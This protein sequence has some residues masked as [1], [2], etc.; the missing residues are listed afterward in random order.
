[1]IARSLLLATFVVV[2]PLIA[3]PA[4]ASEPPQAVVAPP[5]AVAAPPPAVA[6]FD[7]RQARAHQEAWSRHL[8]EPIVAQN[9]VGMSLVLIPP[10]EFLMGGSTE[11]LAATATWAD[12]K[13][14]NPPGT[15]RARI[16]TDEQPPH[17][18]RLTK[19][20]RIGATETTIG[21]YRRFVEASGYVTETERFGGGNS[22]KTAETAPEKKAAVWHRPG[23]RTTDDS[24]VTQLTWNDMVAFCNWLSEQEKRKP[25]YRLDEKKAYQLVA[26][27]GTTTDTAGYRL[28]TEAEWEC[29]C[30]AGTTTQYWFGDDRTK[31]AAHAWFEDNADHTGAQPVATKPANPFGLYDTSGNVW[32]RCQDWHDAKWYTRSP[33]DD[34][35]GPP[36]GTNKVVRGGAWHYFDLHCRS[37]YRNNYKLT[38]RTANTGFRVVR[39]M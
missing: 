11:L 26:D 14:Q 1:V 2:A 6:P 22:S 16:E 28:P 38:G 8:D 39:G 7:A 34:P 29:A 27:S 37:A 21:Q 20:L 31:L 9:S 32:E 13:R 15:E 33:T 25:C 5:Q 3:L 30:R 12:T 24:P 19:P 17:R 36:T 23:Y 18:V 35:Q 10:G 4:I